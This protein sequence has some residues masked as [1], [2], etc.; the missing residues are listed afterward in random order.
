[1]AYLK[2]QKSALVVNC[3]VLT[4][5]FDDPEINTVIM[6]VPT[7]SVIFYLQCVG[8]AIRS[9][10]QSTSNLAYVVEFEDDMPNIHYRIDNK[11]LFADISDR[12]EPQVIEKDYNSSVEFS[13][14]IDQ[15]NALYNIVLDKE[16]IEEA[17]NGDYEQISI[18]VYNSTQLLRDDAWKF[19]L[20]NPNNYRAYSKIFNVLSNRVQDFPDV[21]VNW[22]FDTKFK[23]DDPEGIFQYEYQKTNLYSCLE[24]AYQERCDKLKVERLKYFIFNKTEELPLDFLEYIADCLNKDSLKFDYQQMKSKSFH[25]IIKIPLALGGFEGVYL[26]EHQSDFCVRHIENLKLIKDV[27][28]WTNWSQS[29]YSLNNLLSEVPISPRHFMALPSILGI[30]YNNYLYKI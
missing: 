20:F 1:M 12:L 29:V 27:E 22:L 24:K 10:N 2:T 7:S 26:N 11:W 8:R 14:I 9:P 16:S 30:N 3:G 13:N 6:V 25:S 18:L 17:C 15:I 4:E 21:N 23:F 19:I 28:D 5:G